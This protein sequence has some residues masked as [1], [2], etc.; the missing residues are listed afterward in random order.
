MIHITDENSNK[1]LKDLLNRSKQVIDPNEINACVHSIIEVILF[2]L[3]NYK[4]M[5]FR[6]KDGIYSLLEQLAVKYDYA[7]DKVKECKAADL[8]STGHALEAYKIYRGLLDDIKCDRAFRSRII[9]NRMIALVAVN[10][11]ANTLAIDT[12]EKLC[13]SESDYQTTIRKNIKA[14]SGI[15]NDD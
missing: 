1:I 2:E 7:I 12:L 6:K 8:L 9:N 11:N 4:E 13:D 3:L 14:L 15:R 5:N 10:Q